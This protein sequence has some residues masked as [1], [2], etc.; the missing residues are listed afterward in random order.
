MNLWQLFSARYPSLRAWLVQ[1][2]CALLIATYLLILALRVW[3]LAP[4]N[5]TDWQALALPVWFR[6]IS[7][8]FWVALS[9]HAGLGV[10]DVVHDY[11][12]NVRLQTGLRILVL[13]LL[14]LYGVWAAWLIV[15]V[16]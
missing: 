8:V 1:R 4:V 5:F 16:G 15:W 14:G 2:I 12:A 9:I 11:V 13:I 10:R 3:C 6:F 7:A